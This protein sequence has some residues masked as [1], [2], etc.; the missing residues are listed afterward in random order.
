MFRAGELRALACLG[1][2]PLSF[3]EL[4]QCS[5]LR[6]PV[7]RRLL[8]VLVVTRALTAAAPLRR[9]VSGAVMRAA[10]YPPPARRDDEPT[11]VV[12]LGA[13]A[14]LLDASVAAPR[15]RPPRTR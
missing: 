4:R 12:A 7:L 15:S 6:E 3:T 5:G 13:A 10:P 14:R 1:D 2:E 9:V 11:R 8:Y